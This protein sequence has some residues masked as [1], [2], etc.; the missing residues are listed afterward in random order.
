[1]PKKKTVVPDEQPVEGLAAAETGGE[2]NTALFPE[3]APSEE[4]EN[5]PAG[6]E[7]L[8]N[9]PP[10]DSPAGEEPPSDVPY[11]DI[12]DA[13]A[14]PAEDGAPAAGE[15]PADLPPDSPPQ[16]ELPSGGDFPLGEENPFPDVGDTALFPQPQEDM[17][18]ESDD[19]EY[20]ALLQEL[21]EAEQEEPHVDDPL[22]LDPPP[23]EG[24]AGNVPPPDLP[25]QEE[26]MD[27]ES[28]IQPRCP[29]G[30]S[31]R[32]AESPAPAT[33]PRRDRVLTIAARDEVQTAEE[34]EAIIWHEIQNAHWTR[35]I[36]TGTLD[37]V[38]R[39]ESGLTVAVV[40]YK[41]FRVAIPVK[42]ML[43][44]TGKVPS[45]A[46]FQEL[47]SRMR[48]ILTAR[49][50]SEIDFIVKGHENKSRSVVASR[51]DAMY[52]KRQTF[53]LD[54]DERGEPMIY[55][56]RVVQARVVAVAEK[57]V[58]VEVFGVECPIV[59]RGLSHA[60]LGNAAEHYH[61][62]D[63]IL[64]RVQRITGATVEDL[65]IT[66]DV[67]STTTDTSAE[68]LKKCV[69]QGRYAGRVTDVRGGVLYVRLNNGVNAIAHCQRRY[70]IVRKR[71]R[72]FVVFRRQ[73][74]DKI[75]RFLAQ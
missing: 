74:G 25:G 48:G 40:N 50:G 10:P 46:D 11:G 21:S 68:D 59:A 29:R 7:T 65:S 55:E 5:I 19:P 18:P 3:A 14:L 32:T 30:Q 69:R 63:R 67:R 9:S 2:E 1:M 39:T 54:K 13:E 35:R 17:E 61:V 33:D 15:P 24:L 75:K 71:R 8:F 44:F 42:E 62:G 12:P 53:Y 23:D 27:D 60:W 52:R 26:D 64:V 20:G 66:A 43:L 4:G 51:R 56:G 36:L 37:G 38:E 28:S 47:M 45:G 41:G 72:N 58:R 34:R 22:T 31:R 73:G 16:E 49:L 57:V 6:E 70:E